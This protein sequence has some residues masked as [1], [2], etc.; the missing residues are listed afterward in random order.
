[1]LYNQDNDSGL[2]FR[3]FPPG[4]CGKAVVSDV[5]NPENGSKVEAIILGLIG[6]P[7]EN[8][9]IKIDYFAGKSRLLIDLEF[10]FS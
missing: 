9:L 4:T 2:R 6:I 5:K 8:F 7:V 1:M 10:R 3:G